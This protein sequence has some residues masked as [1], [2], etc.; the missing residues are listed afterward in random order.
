M[1]YLQESMLVASALTPVGLVAG[2]VGLVAVVVV[3]GLVV[4]IVLAFRT[5]CAALVSRGR[6]TMVRL[7]IISVTVPVPGTV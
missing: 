3:A 1:V 4:D 7:R 5:V 6:A 2:V